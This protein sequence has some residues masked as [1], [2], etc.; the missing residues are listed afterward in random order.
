MPSTP[1][2]FSGLKI[3]TANLTLASEHTYFVSFFHLFPPSQ[4]WVL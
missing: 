1:S 3:P 4:V 2:D